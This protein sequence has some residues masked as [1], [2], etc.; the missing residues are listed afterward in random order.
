MDF[1]AQLGGLT[2]DH[3]FK[4]LMQRLLD[5]A[6]T[7]YHALDLPIK[8]RWAS[9]LLLLQRH[10]PLA[11]TEIAER[12]RL[13]HPAVIQILGEMD[14]RGLTVAARDDDDG[15]RRQVTLTTA[16][17]RLMLRLEDVWKELEA[18]Q[19]RAFQDAGWDVLPLLQ[20]IEERLPAGVLAAEVLARLERRKSRHTQH[21]TRIKASRSRSS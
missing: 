5:E 17:R 19:L 3:R 15:R 4:R 1:V 6:E 9:T 13:T 11:V 10:G 16:G 18:V 2:L 21:R 7:V 14:Q 8:P 12:L 20:R